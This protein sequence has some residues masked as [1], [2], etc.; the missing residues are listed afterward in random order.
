M[1]VSYQYHCHV[2]RCGYSR[3]KQLQPGVNVSEHWFR[4][5]G[6][7]GY[8]K[9][10]QLHFHPVF[11][12]PINVCN[13]R[14]DSDEAIYRSI[15]A[16]GFLDVSVPVRHHMRI[17]KE[18]INA[19]LISGAKT[20]KTGVNWTGSMV[21]ILALCFR[22][23]NSRGQEAQLAFNTS[24]SWFNAAYHSQIGA[25]SIGYFLMFGCVGTGRVKL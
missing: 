15:S 8:V 18:K 19:A 20:T 14:I 6:R 16:N 3:K 21:D 7:F 10:K 25:I 23:P 5:V 2:C 12:H 4:H 13:V 17:N 9:I 22:K 1:N 11:F 24:R